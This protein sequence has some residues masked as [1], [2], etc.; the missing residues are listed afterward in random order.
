MYKIK[1]PNYSSKYEF[2][3]KFL[4]MKVIL[5]ITP[6]NNRLNRAKY[7]QI[8]GIWVVLYFHV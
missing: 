5:Y 7:S 1:F 2:N 6:D 8:L 3:G 4:K